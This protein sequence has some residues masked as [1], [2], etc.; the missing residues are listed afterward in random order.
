MRRKT[1]QCFCGILA[2]CCLLL[3]FAAPAAAE[4]P[5]AIRVLLRRLALSDRM[6]LTLSGRYLVRSASG[7][8]LLL[9]EEARV[10]VL[11]RDRQLFLY[12]GGIS[13]GMGAS[14]SFLALHSGDAD[15]GICFNLQP[16][17]YPGSLSVSIEDN[18]LVPILSLPLETYLKGVVPYEMGDGFP[19]EALK[20]QAVCARTYALSR[21]RPSAAWDVVDTTNDQVFRGLNDASPKSMQAVEDT[22]GLVLT[23]D[24]KLIT[25]WYSA[26]NGGQTELPA[27]IWE[28]NAPRCFALTEDPWD[29]ANPESVVRTCV[30]ARDA[31]GLS[32]AFVKLIHRAALADPR[33]RDLIPEED[34]RLSRLNALALTTPRYAA[35]SRLMTRLE[36]TFET[37]SFRN[38]GKAAS[39]GEEEELDIADLLSSYPM[40]VTLDLFPETLIAL[41]L[42]ISGADNEIITLQEDDSAFTLTAGRFG[43]GVGL[44]QRGA[45]QMANAGGKNFQEILSFYFPGAALKRYAGEPSPLPTPPPELARDPG[46]AP[47]A[48]PRPT[49]MPVTQDLPEGARMA[50]VTGIA[51]DSSL[52]LRAQPSAGA[53]ILMR[54]YYRQPLIVLEESDVPGWVHV[55]TDAAEG[56]VMESFLEYETDPDLP[57]G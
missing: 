52:N 39:S 8:E 20:A 25:A 57:K 31:S 12:S 33:L 3:S 1:I 28:G 30:L 2:L 18:R 11:L 23:C 9:P 36:V 19:P 24:G 53:E 43:H 4:S 41:G 45:Q 10:T 49:L 13:A 5:S 26:S 40:T 47:T 38:A 46:P 55:R 54:L 17:F 32:P 37:D 27:N 15:P 48:T 44:S 56:F 34:F 14:C 50:T 29:A 51:Q 35:P 7:S 16:G 42:S 21:M 22:A 6:D